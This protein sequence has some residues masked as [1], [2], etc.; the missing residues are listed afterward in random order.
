MLETLTGRNSA[1]TCATWSAT[2]RTVGFWIRRMAHETAVRNEEAVRSG[3]PL[4][5]N[6]CQS[7]D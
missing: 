5:R 2:D 1:Q 6:Q 3:R 7:E 4:A